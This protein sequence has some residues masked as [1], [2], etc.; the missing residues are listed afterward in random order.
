MKRHFGENFDDG[1]LVK[2]FQKSLTIQQNFNCSTDKDF[3]CVKTTCFKQML[4]NSR[5]KIY[6]PDHPEPQ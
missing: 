4:F 1:D 2:V 3:K 6:L 5:F